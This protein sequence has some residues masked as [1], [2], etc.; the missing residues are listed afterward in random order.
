MENGPIEDVFSIEIGD[1]PASHVSLPEGTLPFF[2]YWYF[3]L[4]K[5]SPQVGIQVL[6]FQCSYQVHLEAILDQLPG[7]W[8][9]QG[10]G[11]S[12]L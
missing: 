3:P 8:W 10:G 4:L 2:D 5:T 9:I 6:Q 1:I 11:F 7:E 12:K